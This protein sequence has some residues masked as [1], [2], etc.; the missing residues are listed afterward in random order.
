[1]VVVEAFSSYSFSIVSFYLS[2]LGLSW[3]GA[4]PRGYMA[5]L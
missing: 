3:H 5:I 2:I 1:M 4:S